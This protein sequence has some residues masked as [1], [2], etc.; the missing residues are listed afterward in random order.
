MVPNDAVVFM[1]GKEKQPLDIC[2]RFGINFSGSCNDHTKINNGRS[3]QDSIPGVID[4][5]TDSNLVSKTTSI[6]FGS[7]D[8]S[9]LNGGKEIVVEQ[10]EQV[11]SSPSCHSMST[12]HVA[13]KS[14]RRDVRNE[15]L[16]DFLARRWHT[17]ETACA[18]SDERLRPVL[19]RC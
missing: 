4:H 18:S 10:P 14:L 17:V 2:E 7:L 1:D 11:S 5:C 6:S 15:I 13:S 12:L 19:L 8:A 16:L 9:M 3:S